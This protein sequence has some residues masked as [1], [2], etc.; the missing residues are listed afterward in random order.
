MISR[1][2]TFIR[3]FHHLSQ[4]RVIYKECLIISQ[5]KVHR[6]LYGP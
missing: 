1:K 2:L 4:T 5:T 6:V 3:L